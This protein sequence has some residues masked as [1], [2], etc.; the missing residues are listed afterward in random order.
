MYDR[1]PEDIIDNDVLL[2]DW[3]DKK[4]DEDKMK[5]EE[6]KI[7]EEDA[8]RDKSKHRRES[9]RVARKSG[10]AISRGSKSVDKQSFT[11]ERS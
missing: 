2:D 7:N 5:R 3:W 9:F 4:L 11:F 6:S 10:S 1:P 8:E